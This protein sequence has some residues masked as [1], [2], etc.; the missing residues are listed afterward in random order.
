MKG[1]DTHK[2]GLFNTR[3]KERM[4]KSFFP[5]NLLIFSVGS[6]GIMHGLKRGIV[7]QAVYNKRFD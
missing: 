1:G 3:S 5:S 4:K 7:L 6:T 2:R